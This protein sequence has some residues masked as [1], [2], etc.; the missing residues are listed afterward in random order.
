MCTFLIIFAF[1]EWMYC[2]GHASVISLAQT[3]QCVAVHARSLVNIRYDV[4][5]P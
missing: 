4:E 2:V 1:N 3:A 5:P